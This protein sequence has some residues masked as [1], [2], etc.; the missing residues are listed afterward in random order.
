MNQAPDIRLV[1]ADDHPIVRSGLRTIIETEP[2]LRV[3]A[4]AG[5]GPTALAAIAEHQPDIAILDVNMPGLSGFEL[6]R[7]LRARQSAVAVIFLTIHSDEVMFNEALD[8]G[9]LGYVLKES[10]VTD[11]VAA[12]KAVAAGHPFV[13]SALTGHLFNRTARA[14]GMAEHKPG[15]GDLTAT[16]R[17]ILRLIAQQKESKDIAEELTISYRTVENHRANICRKLAL[18]GHNALLRFALEHK[19]ELL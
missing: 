17:R 14:A 18:H 13:S 1:I 4:E 9:A 15:L 19:S 11:I 12:V 8:L 5:D 7:Q 2:R 10:A 6:L 3:V 16:E